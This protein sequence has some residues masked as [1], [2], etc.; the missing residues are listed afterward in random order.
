[1]VSYSDKQPIDDIIIDSILAVINSFNR[2]QIQKEK[3]L[4][5]SNGMILFS[6]N[7]ELGGEVDAIHC[8]VPLPNNNHLLALLLY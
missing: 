2:Q 5:T 6:H 7:W 4:L 3:K 1:M 8:N